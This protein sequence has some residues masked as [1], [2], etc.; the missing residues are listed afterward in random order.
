MEDVIS[1]SAKDSTWMGP[2]TIKMLSNCIQRALIQ[3]VH[4]WLF[5]VKVT[6]IFSKEVAAA[7]MRKNMSVSNL[8][9]TVNPAT[10]S[11]KQLNK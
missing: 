2:A 8:D 1:Q 9:S 11:P 7:V 4:L 10:I 3:N 6:K 5:H